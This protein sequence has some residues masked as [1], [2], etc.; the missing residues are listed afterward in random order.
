M[1]ALAGA[2]LQ[3]T[4]PLAVA[5]LSASETKKITA[6]DLVQAAVAL[7]DD[8]SIPGAKVNAGLAPGSVGTA[9]LA[10]DAVT[11]AKLADQSSAVIAGTLPATGAYIGQLGVDTSTTP[12]RAYIW[13]G[14]GWRPFAGAGGI[15]SAVGGTTGLVN[16]YVAQAGGVT[17]VTA[18]LDAAGSAGQFLAGPSGTAGAI[19]LRGIVST[20]MPVATA[21]ARGAVQVNGDGLVMSGDR[22]TIDNTVAASTTGHLVRYNAKGLVTGGSVITSLDLPVA[23]TTSIGAIRAG[24]DL[25]VDA[26]GTL[27]HTNAVVAGTGTKVTYDANGHITS[28]A[29]LLPTDIPDLSAD[30]ITSGLLNAGLFAD[31][32]IT[33]LMLAN[34]ATAYIQDTQ[35]TGTDHFAGQLW[36]NPLAQQIRMWDS[37]VW[38]PI[39]VGALS[40][41]NL[42]FCGLFN[43]DTGRVTVVTKFGQDAGYKVGDPFLAANEQL[44]GAYLVCDTPGSNLS[45]TP[46]VTYDAGDWCLCIGLPGYERVDTLSGVGGGGSTTLDGLLDVTLTN[47]ANGEFLG[48]DGVDWINQ[49][50]PV[51]STTLLGVARLA[52]AAAVTAGT[53]GRVVTADQLKDT[54]DAVATNTTNITTVQGQITTIN[55]K[56]VD[57]TTTVKGIVQLADG[58]AITAGT[59][60]RAVTADQLKTTNDAVAANTA[61]ITANT[62]NITTI[63]G[64]IT[65]IQ[66]Q[67]VDATTAVKGIVQL[68]D[69]AAVTAG[70]AGR[71]V[72]ADQLKATNDAVATAVGGGVTTIN[73]TA[74]ISVTGTGNTRTVAV[75]SSSETVVG[76]VQLATAAETTAGT[77]TTKA[78]HPAGLKVELDK[79]ANATA[80]PAA[81][82][83]TP[84]M[85]GTG[86]VGTGTAYARADHVHPTDTSRAPLASPAL[87]GT[88]TA[89]TA[90]TGTNTTQL[91]TTAFVQAQVAS[92]VPVASDTVQG[93]VE[94]ATAAEVGTG[95]DTTRAVT[96]A[97]VAAHYLQKNIANLALLP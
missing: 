61:S 14:S 21:G 88:P 89:P 28:T 8:G 90:T 56:T 82:S 54:N 10:N 38:V 93:K 43:A 46:A 96:A 58:A 34:Y 41:Q 45:V 48:F 92:S 84:V 32:S 91:A 75:A 50:L 94:L 31:R 36:L 95:T 39:G 18:D 97:G 55:N 72:T 76:A 67:T 52:D 44:T 68:A 66:G 35:P 19:S 64:Q 87:T 2:L 69:A 37:N 59:A 49:P 20:D 47:P 51:A 80:V 71:V 24:T 74:P 73:G 7:I 5:D 3:A 78:V 62:T 15:A 12:P 9:E 79:K 22:V 1:P 23:S 81:A 4:D 57:A 83:T 86:A 70:T 65:T 60:G 27:H 6:K 40:E 26:G 16:T 42:R 53:A 25:T 33:A 85:D 13:D 29:P 11:A 63:Q 17:T 30:K 77:S